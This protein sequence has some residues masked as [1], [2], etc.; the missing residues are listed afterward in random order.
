[1]SQLKKG[2]DTLTFMI[3]NENSYNL[4]YHEFTYCVPIN[5]YSDA[6]IQ[7]PLKS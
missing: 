5:Y 7:I 2:E 3:S 1:M 4:C 6:D